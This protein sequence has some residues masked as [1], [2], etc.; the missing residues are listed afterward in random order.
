MEK[1]DP[2]RV[3]LLAVLD[4]DGIQA[5]DRVRRIAS[6][7]GRSPST[8]RRWLSVD[9]AAEKMMGDSLLNLTR[10]LDVDLLWLWSGEGETL[11]P[12]TLRINLQQVKGYPKQEVDRI[13]RLFV[14][15]SAGQRKA[16]RL[17]DLVMANKLSLPAAARLM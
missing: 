9:G 5:S 8:A 6:A 17:F 4:Y 11:A 15:W 12:R 1:H 14:A 7:S 2:I 3:R 10:D 13:M 16:V